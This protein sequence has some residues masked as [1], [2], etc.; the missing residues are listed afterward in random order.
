M[1]DKAKKLRTD[2]AMA[3]VG[4]QDLFEVNGSVYCVHC[5]E[6]SRVISLTETRDAGNYNCP[7]LCKGL[8]T[9]S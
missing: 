6:N 1:D 4:G 7:Y 8:P 2:C 9:G 3:I 5:F